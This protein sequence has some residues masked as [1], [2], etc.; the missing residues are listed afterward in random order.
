VT[1]F[2]CEIGR[3][4]GRGGEILQA[5]LG[6]GARD[7]TYYG[8]STAVRRRVWRRKKRILA[9]RRR[10]GFRHNSVR[11]SNPAPS[12]IDGRVGD[13]I[14]AAPR[15]GAPIWALPATAIS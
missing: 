1:R 4:I 10:V 15:S 6:R 9:L 8:K 3:V 14:V 5:K 12:G 11:F 13:E 2:D 7:S